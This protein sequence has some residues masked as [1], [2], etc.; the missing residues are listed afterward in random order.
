LGLPKQASSLFA[1]GLW[2]LHLI[3]RRY[4]Q[5]HTGPPRVYG[6]KGKPL[7]ACRLQHM[8]AD[9]MIWLLNEPLTAAGHS[10]AMIHASLPV[11][12]AYT[13][14]HPFLQYPHIPFTQM[15]TQQ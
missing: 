3:Q 15:T 7:P 9:D 10:V 12:C 1:F 8:S 11:G 6:I 5:K 13:S 14:P 4:C 2:L